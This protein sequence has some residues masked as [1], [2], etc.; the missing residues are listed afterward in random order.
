M[1]KSLL[2]IICLQ[3]CNDWAVLVEKTGAG[4]GDS[5]L[6]VSSPTSRYQIC[7]TTGLLFSGHQCLIYGVMLLLPHTPHVITYFMPRENHDGSTRRGT[8]M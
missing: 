7:N 3:V 1:R 4:V 2:Q 5:D 8:I 6:D